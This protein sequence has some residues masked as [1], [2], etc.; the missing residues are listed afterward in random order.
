MLYGISEGEVTKYGFIDQLNNM[1]QLN[2]TDVW[3]K[4]HFRE[5][6]TH[7]L[8]NRLT[9]NCWVFC[10]QALQDCSG[11]LRCVCRGLPGPRVS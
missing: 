4:S 9:I 3:C 8:L 2:S 7:W 1:I 5:S 11:C 6:A 10:F